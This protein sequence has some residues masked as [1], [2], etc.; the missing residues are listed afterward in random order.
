[1]GSRWSW[2]MVGVLGA[3]GCGD[4]AP[5]GEPIV[6]A[7]AFDA[8]G[9]KIVDPATGAI[10]PVEYEAQ[11]RAWDLATIDCRLGVSFAAAYPGYDDERPTAYQ[12]PAQVST[13]GRNGAGYTYELGGPP[14]DAPP[15]NNIFGSV[16]DQVMYVPTAADDPGVS[17][18]S[19]FDWGT[20]TITEHPEPVWWG[21]NNA[22]GRYTDPSVDPTQVDAARAAWVTALGR[23]VDQPVTMA[24]AT[25]VWSNDAIMVFK[26]GLL[27]VSGSQTSADT[28]PHFNFPADKV[29]MTVAVTTGNEFTLVGIWD[30][31]THQGQLAVLANLARGLEPYHTWPYFGLPSGGSYTAFKLLGYVDLPFATPTSIAAGANKDSTVPGATT[32][33]WV[34]LDT[35]AARDEAREPRPC[36]TCAPNHAVSTAGYALVA[37]RWENQVAV[38]DL[39]PLYGFM[40][41]RYLTTQANFDEAKP[42]DP[43]LWPYTFA[44]HPAMTPTV[45]MTVDVPAPV[46]MLA[47]SRRYVDGTVAHIAS[48]DGTVGTY[49]SS[50]FTG[51]A[52]LPAALPRLTTV[53]VGQA[54]MAM[55]WP[56][57]TDPLEPAS[58]PYDFRDVFLVVSRT[59]RTLYWVSSVDRAASRVFR[60]FRDARM[61]DP[62][63]V[64]VGED[65]Y[66]VTVADFAGHKV[67]N[68]RFAPTPDHFN[69]AGVAFGL[70]P[71]GTAA[72]ECGGELALQ[73]A[74]FEI[75][76]TNVN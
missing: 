38:V 50:A 21:V 12:P 8:C 44:T 27:G 68:Y 11:A 67:I 36:D 61:S 69:A 49:D 54:P 64:D 34:L 19:T 39:R 58:S 72:A 4:P 24:R 1:M 3:G 53:Q 13:I 18:I 35:Q 42:D 66:I 33:G 30:T 41:D 9:G 40:I 31:T 59:E 71:D 73:G 47:G 5:R 2:V 10:D 23:P 28:F 45:A 15:S 48:Y 43:A 52:P 57:N 76:S 32:S 17:R 14:S 37:S 25:T 60:T 55:A 20:N 26:P 6:P 22:D 16:I 29:V 7:D 51:D 74:V 75:S 56:R 63:D 62:V 46:A 70:G 65:A